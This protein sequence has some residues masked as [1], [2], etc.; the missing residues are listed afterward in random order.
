M[1]NNVT[2]NHRTRHVDIRTKFVMQ[3]T[4]P[5]G[6]MKIIFVKGTEN[7][8]DIFTKNVTGELHDKHIPKMMKSL[9]EDSKET[10]N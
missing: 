5:D 10:T 7:D 1:S 8:S 4:G 9:N 2:T 3:Y 6:M